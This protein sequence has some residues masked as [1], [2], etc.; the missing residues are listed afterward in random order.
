MNWIIFAIYAFLISVLFDF[1]YLGFSCISIFVG[2]IILLRIKINKQEIAIYYGVTRKTLNKWF[3]HT[4]INLNYQKYKLQR[5]ISLFQFYKIIEEFGKVESQKPLTKKIIKEKCQMTYKE[6][7][8][9]ISKNFCG[10]SQEDY[11]KINI[12]PP[13]IS[14]RILTHLQLDHDNN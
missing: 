11:L 4:P 12:F 7:R 6:L 2:T 13:K 3:T 9:C 10:I 5:K 14:H 1:V 8:N